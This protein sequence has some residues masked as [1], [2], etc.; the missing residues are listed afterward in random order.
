MDR[1]ELNMEELDF[2]AGGV[3]MA[4]YDNDK[5]MDISL[6]GNER[7]QQLAVKE[8]EKRGVTMN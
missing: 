6:H 2:V 1:E 3:S 8:L 7:E 5:L 4:A